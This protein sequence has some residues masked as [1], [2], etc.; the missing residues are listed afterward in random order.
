MKRIAGKD[1]RSG[2]K[3]RGQETT[4]THGWAVGKGNLQHQKEEM[5]DFLKH[6]VLEEPPSTDPSAHSGIIDFLKGALH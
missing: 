5:Y 2:N 4:K 6:L 3:K 1:E